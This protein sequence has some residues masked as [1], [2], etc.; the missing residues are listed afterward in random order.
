MASAAESERGSALVGSIFGMTFLLILSLGAVEIGLALYARNVVASAVHEGARAAVELGRDEDDAA[1][2]AKTVVAD[3]AGALLRDLRVAAEL[4]RSREG[5]GRS[6]V[7]ID[8]RI[9][10]LGP[11]PLSIP[12]RMTG[13]ASG[14]LVV[15]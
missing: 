11:I 3:A 12:V 6:S 7:T 9:R 10:L 8:G 5:V 15:P 1:A 13:S 2:I 14:Q 4:V